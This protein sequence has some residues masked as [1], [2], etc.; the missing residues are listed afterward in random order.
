MKRFVDH[1]QMVEKNRAIANWNLT[2]ARDKELEKKGYTYRERQKEASC[3]NCKSKAKCP[4]F[5][6]KKTGGAAGVVSFGGSN[7]TFICSKYAPAEREN[8]T[9]SDKQIKS[10]LKNAKRGLR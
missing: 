6:A 5:R 1:E 7:E 2:S 9:M 10:L 8:R 3:F 4:E